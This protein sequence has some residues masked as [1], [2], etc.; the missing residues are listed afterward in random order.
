MLK[1]TVLVENSVEAIYPT[2]LLAEHGLSLYIEFRDKKILFDTGQTD[3]LI[4]NARVLEIDLKKLDAIVLSHGHYDHTGGLKA[5]LE[6]LQKPIKIFAHPDVFLGH[7]YCRNGK[8][9]YI[10]IPYKR[11]LL[12]SLGAEFV[13]TKEPIEIFPDFFVSGEVPRHT[14]FEKIDKKMVFATK[15]G[16]SPDP[17]LDDLSIFIKTDEG[18]LVLLGCAH[19]G[20]INILEYAKSLTRKEVVGIIGGTH[21]ISATARQLKETLKY[22]DNLYLKFFSPIHCTGYKMR[23]FLRNRYKKIFAWGGVG[24]IFELKNF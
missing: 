24:K 1:V 22:L 2:G 5:L 3:I 6:Y 10:G 7:Y 16:F 8:Y 13:L 11:E 19:A 20:L 4:R 18:V 21:L 14:P 9:T 17:I 23:M 12:E 15:H